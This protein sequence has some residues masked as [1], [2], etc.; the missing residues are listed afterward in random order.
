MYRPI[1]AFSL[2][3]ALLAAGCPAAGETDSASP[4]STATLGG[5]SGG[6]AGDETS[7][8]GPTSAGVTSAVPTTDSN[9][10]SDPTLDPTDSG[11]GCDGCINA[12]GI[13]ESGEFDDACGRGG[14]PCLV[15]DAPAECA[16]GVCEEPPQCG[17]SN[18]DGCCDGDTCVA[19][20]T[21]DACGTDGSEC[22]ACGTEASCIG[23]ACELPCEETC[24]GCCNADGTCVED[25]DSNDAAC[26]LFGLS[27]ETC[28][29]DQFCDFGICSSPTCVESCDGCCIGDTCYDGFEEAQCGYQETC[30]VC[31]AG[32]TCNGL[33][34]T[35]NPL[36]QWQVV[37]LDGEVTNMQPGG[38]TW[39]AFGGAPD[40]YLDIAELEFESSVVDNTVDPV[41]FETV[42]TGTLAADLMDPLTFRMRDSDVLVDQVIGT[43]TIELPEDAF[44]GLHE[45]VC[46]VDGA[47]AWSVLLSIQ[48][49]Q[50]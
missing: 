6:D 47:F 13:C 43:C 22:T 18:C 25:G 30:E 46:E 17:P 36:T 12:A 16:E 5:S 19:S 32:Q 15:C 21:D 20:P 33:D 24:F 23:G 27:C 8:S 49:V 48:T 29:G 2:L 4:T 50:K 34:C 44:G 31:S 26:G 7:T 3:G 42:T 45:V 10:D 38:G 14:S 37:L 28:V 9:T 41:W 40:P 39:D 35:L 11:S 1:G